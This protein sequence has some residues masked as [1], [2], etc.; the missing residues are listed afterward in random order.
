ME[1]LQTARLRLVPLSVDA[2][3]ALVSPDTNAP[4]LVDRPVARAIPVKL[5]KTGDA[6]P[7]DHAW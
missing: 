2:L 5:E 3:A 7:E 4:G 1:I 6:P